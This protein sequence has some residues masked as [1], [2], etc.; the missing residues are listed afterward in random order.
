M[1]TVEPDFVHST[2]LFEIR[3][4]PRLIELLD[5]RNRILRERQLDEFFVDMMIQTNDTIKKYLNLDAT[6]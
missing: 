2:K 6:K 3:D 1:K 5:Y 4:L